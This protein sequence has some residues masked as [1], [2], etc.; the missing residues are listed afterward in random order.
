MILRASLYLNAI[1]LLACLLLGGLWKYEVHRKELVIAKYAKAQVEA[2]ARARDAEIRNV[3]NIARIADIY[4][5][6][7]RA[8]DEAQRKLVADLRAGTVRLQKRWAGCVSE[9]GATAAERDAAARDREESVA[10]VLRAARDADSQI[11]ALQD[12]VR[13]DRGQ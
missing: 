7:K 1:L 12:V 11:R 6:D 2:Q 4:E 13:A 8:A 10:R 5:R 3:Q 9:A